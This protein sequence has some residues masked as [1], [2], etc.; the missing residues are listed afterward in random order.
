MG[1][2]DTILI[3]DDTELNRVI[4]HELFSSEYNI[5]EAEN[6]SE[7]ISKIHQF[8]KQIAVVL[9]DI[10]MPIKDGFEVLQYLRQSGFLSTLP[11]IVITAEDS[12]ES[13]VRAFDLGATDIILKPFVPHVVKRRVQNAVDLYEHKAHL[14]EV[15]EEQAQ[16]LKETNDTIVDGLSSIIE[17]R[18]L[19]SGQHIRRIRS[20]TKILLQE[21]SKNYSEYLLDAKTIELISSASSMHDIGK[22][23]IPDSILNKPGK[24]T[25]EEFEVMKTHTIKGCEILEGFD[26]LNDKAYLNFAY[27]ICRYHHERW[28]GRGYPDGIKGDNIPI[29]AQVVS[30]AD[31]YD[32]LTTPR[33]YKPAFSHEIAVQMI[34]NGE[35]G[36]FSSKILTCFQNVQDKFAQLAREYADGHP[37]KPEKIQR[38]KAID[39]HVG[40]DTKE[41]ERQKYYTLLKYVNSTVLEIDLN[42][43]LYQVVYMAS[44]DFDVLAPDGL[45]EE[46]FLKFVNTSVFEEDRK[47]VLSCLTDFI[48]EIFIDGATI[49]TQEYRIFH[50]LT[51]SY[52]WHKVTTM[53][54]YG[55][56]PHIYRAV[57]ILSDV[58]AQKR[59]EIQNM[60]DRERILFALQN[61]YNTSYEN[62]L[63]ADTYSMIDTPSSNL[64]WGTYSSKYSDAVLAD[65][66]FAVHPEDKEE[67]INFYKRENAKA[68]FE[69]F[70]K[71]VL[72]YRRLGKDGAY[73]WIEATC[74]KSKEPE[75]KDLIFFCFL[76][77]IEGKK[78]IQIT[79][80]K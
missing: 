20:F 42:T 49:Y 61:T 26:R 28:D 33:V 52:H 70:D 10:V 76:K 23:A 9:L 57:I 60:T 6:G 55:N 71:K 35:C 66:E 45:F 80:I 15:V 3:V 56:S 72:V 65:A 51:S 43:G 29:C 47:Q 1:T 16:E 22:I 34:F 5:M 40:I 37:V 30:I 8:S 64:A 4:L 69:K 75:N 7:A 27:N 63:T 54:V 11:V 38:E 12:P 77:D 24:L 25:A 19:E 2:R 31:V 62:N 36:Q 17:Y 48:R 78:K 46:N 58:D 50:R 73:H 18:S 41:Y 68:Y 79:E 21:V 67:F 44:N 13:E 14:E 74:V 59:V 32:A 53:R 39:I